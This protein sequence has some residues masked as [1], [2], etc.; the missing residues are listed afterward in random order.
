MNASP[1]DMKKFTK[2]CLQRPESL[3]VSDYIA[4]PIEV[5]I[6]LVAS[7][8]YIHHVDFG[9]IVEKIATRDN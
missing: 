9:L 2:A 5:L 8:F 6:L 3:R 7:I 4:M 1:C